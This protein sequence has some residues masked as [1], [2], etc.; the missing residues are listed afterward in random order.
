[1]LLGHDGRGPIVSTDPPMCKIRLA[2]NRAPAACMT[3]PVLHEIAEDARIYLSPL[4]LFAGEGGGLPRLQGGPLAFGAWEAAL[5]RGGRIEWQVVPAPALPEWIARLPGR[6]KL[7]AERLAA[8]ITSPLP[9]PLGRA[10]A[11]LLMGVINVTPDSFS[12]G[13][14][15]LAPDA[16]IRRGHALAEAGARILDIGGEST[17][18]GAS[19]VPP[20]DE[21]A[22]V[23]PVLQGLQSLRRAAPPVALSV[24]TRHAATMRAA[25]AA[26]VDI[27]NDVSAL[28]GDGSL[29][30]AAAGAADIVLM[31]MAGEPATMNDAPVYA[32]VALDVFDFLEARIAACEAAGIPRRRL[33]LDPGIGFGKRGAE[34]L[35]VLGRIALFH[36]L[37]CPLLLGASRKGFGPETQALAPA[38]RLPASLA[39]AVQALSQGV[40]ILRVHDVAET[41]QAAA[42]WQRLR[43]GVAVPQTATGS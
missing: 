8:A 13:G 17:R 3:Q 31:H 23:L 26:G 37:G 28:R 15:Y 21:I 35:A 4:G 29:E 42:L 24:D 34:N 41:R 36:G 5:R 9:S 30:I 22:R 40:R 6:L 16:A 14:L 7:R 39:A 38:A 18:P 11:P 32:D 1:M 19:P 20:E 27:V 12:D 25:L 2:R 10:A 33:I 43:D